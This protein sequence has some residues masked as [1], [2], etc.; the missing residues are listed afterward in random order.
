MAAPL[1]RAALRGAAALAA[2]WAWPPAGAEHEFSGGGGLRGEAVAI[3]EDE[4]AA[5]EALAQLEAAAHVG[6]PPRQLY[7]AGAEAE[8]VVVGDG[9]GVATAQPRSELPRGGT[10]RG[11]RVGGG[12][13]EACVEVGEELR[14]E[15]VGRLHGA[16]AAQAQLADE[17]VLQGLPEA[18]DAPPWLA[19]SARRC[20][21]CRAPAGCGRSAWGLAC[22]GALPPASSGHRCARRRRGGRHRGPAAARRWCRSCEAGCRSRAGPRWG[23]RPRPGRCRW[24]R[25]SPHAG[26]GPGRGPRARRRGWRRVARGRPSGLRAGGGCGP[27][28]RAGGGWRAA[29]ACGGGAAPSCDSAAARPPPG[30]SR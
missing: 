13:G 18:F 16:D 6:P 12:P 27:D 21:Q 1:D 9:A 11:P 3:G 15:G 7:P 23:G 25:Q 14:Q 4:E 30:A 29:R 22:R 20:S 19:G 24:R 5:I 28:G 8:G 26:P 10:P 2:V 17:A